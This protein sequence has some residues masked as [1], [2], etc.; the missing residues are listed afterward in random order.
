ML[1]TPLSARPTQRFARRHRRGVVVPLVAILLPVLLVL[2]GF[3][4]DVAYMQSTQAELR[5]A[6]DNAA[7][8]GAADLALN[9]NVA[10]ARAR[11]LQIAESNI[12]AGRPLQLTPGSIQFGRSMPNQA[13][14]YD[15]RLGIQPFNAVRVLGDRSSN[16]PQ[17]GVPLYFGSLI[18]REVFEPDTTAIASFINYDICLVLDRSGSMK[19]DLS[20]DSQ[21]MV[22]SNPRYCL[23]AVPTS[24]WAALSDAVDVFVDLVNAS[25]ASERV[26]LVTYGS[27]IEGVGSFSLC[28]GKY[29]TTEAATIDLPLTSNASLLQDEMAIWA[30]SVFNGLTFIDLGILRGIQAVT[31]PGSRQS[32]EKVLVVLTDGR[33]TN[34]DALAAAEACADNG[35][36]CYTITFAEDAD[37]SLMEEVARIGEG[38]HYHANTQQELIDAFGHVIG[39]MTRITN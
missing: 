16:S 27:D 20:A 38:R 24:R 19:R 18:G 7:R 21:N 5:M 22:P 8:A 34:G 1:N 31:G 14:R 23:P 4:V 17:G 36:L 39:E 29:R 32:A 2:L 30:N 11:A 26:S 37:K 12:V 25:N 9:D 13:G 33:Q 15:F 35:I 3:S 10:S 28:N 6:T